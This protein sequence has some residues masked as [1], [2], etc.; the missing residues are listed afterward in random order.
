MKRP[1][2][3]SPN[4]S[5]PDTVSTE[6]HAGN[7][8]RAKEYTSSGISGIHFGMYK[9]QA[10]YQDLAQYDAT[11]RSIM[12]NTGESYHRWHTGVDVMLLKASGDTRAHKLRTILLLE[13][14]FNMKTSCLVAKACGWLKSMKAALR[15]NNVVDDDITE[16]MK[17][18]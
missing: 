9:A 3:L 5:I 11:S 1:P 18:H 12:Y 2:S 4:T 6:E 10:A 8:K 17:H 16:L 7:L 13:A 14:D 15:A